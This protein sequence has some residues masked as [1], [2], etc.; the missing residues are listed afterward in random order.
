[1]MGEQFTIGT[2]PAGWDSS[3]LLDEDDL[4][5]SRAIS[6]EFWYSESG[7][8]T[9]VFD[10]PKLTSA[11]SSANDSPKDPPCTLN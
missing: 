7:A 9:E 10:G 4:M 6:V 3:A 5:S 2:P 8:V 11:W 1:M